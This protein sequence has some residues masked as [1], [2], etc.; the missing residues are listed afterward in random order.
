MAE[1]QG[2]FESVQ[3]NIRAARA[4][5]GLRHTRSTDALIDTTFSMRVGETVVVG[6]SRVNGDRALIALM[7]AVS[8]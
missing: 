2:A 7:T 3:E 5:A 8:R 4:A 1:T 6:T